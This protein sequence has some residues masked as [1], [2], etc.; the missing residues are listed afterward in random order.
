M[1]IINK[2]FLIL[3]LVVIASWNLNANERLVLEFDEFMEVVKNQHPV[4][5]KAILFL[6]AGNAK[7][8]KSQGGFDPKLK[9]KY[10]DKQFQETNYYS[11]FG[12]ELKIPTWFGVD[13]KAGYEN[14]NGQYLNPEAKT[15]NGGLAYAGINLTL[16]KGLIINQRRAELKK[17]NI[18]LES[19]KMEQ[20]LLLNELYLDATKA[21][22]EWFSVFHQLKIMEE[23]LLNAERR[24]KVIKQNALIGEQSIMDTVEAKVQVNNRQIK[25]RSFQIKLIKAKNNLNLFLWSEGSIPLVVENN[26]KPES[27]DKS[28]ANIPESVSDSL[29]LKHPKIQLM[30]QKIQIQGIDI[31]LSRESLKPKLDLSYNPL[32]E[33]ADNQVGGFDVQNQKIGVNFSYPVFTRKARGDYRLNKIKQEQKVLDLSVE[34]ER[35]KLNANSAFSEWE[36]YAEQLILFTQLKTNYE[37]LSR[38]E[39]LLF[40]AGESSFFMVNTREKAYI[41]SMQGL[42][43]IIQSKNEALGYYNYTICK[44]N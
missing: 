33:V 39:S 41:Q 32:Y 18:F 19:S 17:A 29:L 13:L 9:A 8:L 2:K 4:S 14:N 10:N 16:G 38:S 24:F 11:N 42:V 22:W 31:A 44:I 28:R 23:A 5:R 21:Y 7:K 1:E 25:V 34:K 40:K 30:E 36:N 26:V 12:A 6:E 27:L 20:Q 35:I 43:K 3:L 37:K 15:P